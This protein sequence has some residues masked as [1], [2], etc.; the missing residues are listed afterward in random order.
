MRSKLVNRHMP[1]MA[2]WLDKRAAVKRNRLPDHLRPRPVWP[3]WI[4]IVLNIGIAYTLIH[5]MFNRD[6][7]YTET[8]PA[9]IIGVCLFLLIFTIIEGLTYRTRYRGKPGARLAKINVGL[10][11]FAFLCLPLAVCIFMS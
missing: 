7:Y 8:G 5:L 11:I 9:F 1:T 10:M 6:E 4:Q 3:L 2:Q